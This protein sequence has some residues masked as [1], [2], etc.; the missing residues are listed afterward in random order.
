MSAPHGTP[1]AYQVHRRRGEKPCVACTEAQRQKITA[2]RAENPGVVR[3]DARA[4]KFRN[5][6]LARLRANH[7]DEF[8]R[9]LMEAY[10]EV[11]L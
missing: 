4:A 8:E 6:A 5:R 10:R 9:L 11:T 7:P 1:A 2:F 3:A